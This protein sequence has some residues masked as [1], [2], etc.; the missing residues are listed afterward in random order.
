M[1]A[2][3][4]F[5]ACVR[6]SVGGAY[7]TP[8]REPD[9]TDCSGLVARCYREATGERISGDSH[10]Q[11]T[12]GREVRHS[13][14]PGDVLLFDTQEGRE[15]RRGNL[16][17]HVGVYLGGD[18]MVSA[19]NEGAG[20]VESD[21]DTPYW[22]ERKRGARRLIAT[23]GTTP[24]TR[25]RERG[26]ASGKPA[27]GDHPLSPGAG[28]GGSSPPPSTPANPAATATTP[29]PA[30]VT[31]ATPFRE[32]G[33]TG[34]AAFRAALAR[35]IAGPSPVAPEADAIYDVLAPLGLTR[36]A[37]GMAW[38]ERR[39]ETD[40]GG[41]AY[42]PRALHNLWAVKSP[43]GDWR[44]FGSYTEAAR[45]W[46]PYVLGPTYQDLTSIA[47]FIAFY[48]PWS[49]GNN[50][51]AYGRQLAAEIN[52]L[53]LAGLEDG[54]VANA[55]NWAPLPWPAMRDAIVSKPYDGAGF[56]RVAARG[57]RMV[58]SCNHITD[59]DPLTDE[60][61]WYRAFFSTGGERAEDALTDLVIAR[62]GE[63]GLLNDWRDPR[64]G[65]T[66]AGWANGTTDGLEGDGIA[67]YQWYPAI[68]D[69][70]MSKEHVARAGQPLTDAQMASSIALS[71][72]QAQ[73]VQCP[74]DSYPYHPGRHGV[75]IE[76]LHRNFAPKACPAEPFISTHYPVLLREVKA[77]LAKHQT[78][79]SNPG[80]PSP[81]P[82]PEGGYP[83]GF[84]LEAMEWF[85]GELERYDGATFGFDPQGPLSLLWLARCRVEGKFPEAESWMQFDGRDV[86][87]WE[88]GWTAVRARDDG[89]AT[90][91]WLD[92]GAP[93][94]TLVLPAA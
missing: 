58:G 78:G 25:G 87:Q 32:A 44:R 63:I 94:P 40:P 80:T 86:V 66:R 52:G 75:N 26:G 73:A 6:R 19:L 92:K 10:V 41:L 79:S 69:V 51:D 54:D 8:P 83:F 93:S 27:P 55:I 90:W 43:D 50:P 82:E 71:A 81:Q 34:R 59:G 35:T 56:N 88:G 12:L 36:L 14:K 4:R 76:Q 46:G 62:S 28:E 11:A 72:A 7:C 89:R 39:N 17:S 65:G 31:P 70:L 20:I 45:Q 30:P 29:A 91:T 61:E 49:D 15:A 2:A 23:D 18:R 3:D 68:N 5:V 57:P 37:A 74:W 9:C 84:G 24:P 42:Y 60:I 13:L 1:S 33:N 67:F 47:E 77:I 48:A 85:W 22:R 21:L 64:R 38:I 16:I 53:P